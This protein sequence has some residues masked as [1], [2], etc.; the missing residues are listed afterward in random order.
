MKP[1]FIF[2]L[3]FL[4]N[5]VS[6]QKDINDVFKDERVKHIFIEFTEELK[7]SAYRDG[8]KI[9]IEVYSIKSEN[10]WCLSFDNVDYYRSDDNYAKFSYKGF[11]VYVNENVPRTIANFNKY[12]NS[13][14]FPPP[15]D[16]IYPIQEFLEA[17]LCFNQDSISVNRVNYKNPDYLNKWI[18]FEND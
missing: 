7:E 13:A 9:F 6:C 4:V 16:F 17:N 15:T 18:Y 3:L 8:N 2:Y 10:D 12:E 5:V 1:N 14:N 11:K